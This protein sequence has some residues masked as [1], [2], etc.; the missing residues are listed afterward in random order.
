MSYILNAS[1]SI[2][3]D[4]DYIFH[5]SE[6]P[7]EIPKNIDYR[8]F[9]QPVRNQGSQGT[10]YAQSAA[11]MKEMQEKTEYGLNEYL[12]PQFFY[13]H[14][15][16]WNNGEQDGEDVNE[17]YG[18]TGRDVMRILKNVGI[19]KETEYPYGTLDT[20][21]EI[22]AHLKV[23][24]LNHT[25]K[26]YARVEELDDLKVSLVSN[27]L[28]LIAFPVYNYSDEMWIQNENESMQG[29]HAMTVVGFDDEKCHFIIR[30][31]WGENWGDKGYC[32]YKYEDWG[33]HWE[34]WTTIDDMKLDD[35]KSETT[36]E[37]TVYDIIPDGKYKILTEPYSSTSSNS[38]VIS[39]SS[40]LLFYFRDETFVWNGKFYE[41][42]DKTYQLFS[43]KLNGDDNTYEIIDNSGNDIVIERIF[44]Y[45]SDEE[46]EYE[47]ETITCWDFLVSLFKKK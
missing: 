36:E 37:S 6:I 34:C 16:Y 8:S 44:E 40:Y 2:K 4:R 14:R 12:S 38:H 43:R 47:E 3:D 45:D 30:N 32:Y 39:W 21:D 15:D 35:D 28:C 29:G 13:N 18:M 24:A 7:D 31:S 20:V 26:S 11:C 22:P 42:D 5:I 23:K 19:C 17:D 1:K 46:T 9:L 10:C 27:G 41:D 33:S 25:I